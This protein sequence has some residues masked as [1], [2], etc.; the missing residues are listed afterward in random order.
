MATLLIDGKSYPVRDGQNLLQASLEL[1]L[2]LPYFCWHPALGSV[3]ACRQCAVKM[4]KDGQD[5]QGKLVMACMTPA[6]DGI[7]ISL[8]DPEARAFRASVI[9]WLMMSHPHDC[10]VCDEGGECHLQD[11]TVMTGHA[12]RRFRGRK[13]T[14]RN[15]DLGPFINHEMNRCIQCY[16]CVRFYRDYAGGRDFDAFAQRDHVYFGRHADGPLENEFSGNLVE[17]CPT[18]VFDD[19]TFKQHYTRKW[20]LQTA[21]SVCVHCGL[22]CNTIPGERYGMLRRIRNRYNGE[23]NGYFLCDRGRYGY[24]F[25][26][27]ERRPRQPVCRERADAGPDTLT[28][29]QAVSQVAAL[30]ADRRRVI[31]IGS[32]RASLEANFALRTLVGDE[33][34]YAGIPAPEQRVLAA[35]RQILLDGPAPT[36]SLRQVADADAVLVLG[37]D[38]TE[39]A[40]LLALA[41]RQSVRQQPME[42]ARRLHIPEWDDTAVRNALQ[43]RRGPVFLAA[44]GSTRLDDA[45]REAWHAAPADIARLGFVVAHAID[46]D[47][48]AV[49]DLSGATEEFA[50]RIAKALIAAERPVIVAG[51]GGGDEAAIHAAAN[52][53]WALCRSGRDARLCFTVPECNSLGLAFFGER[54]LDDAF[55]A[56]HDGQVDTLIVLEN[57]LY[58]R[59]TAAAMDGMLRSVKH[60]V[61]IDHSPSATTAAAEILLPAATFAESQGTLVNNEGRAQRF[62][63]IMPAAGDILTSWRWLR[64]ILLATGREPEWRDTDAVTAACAHA[65]PALARIT[66]AAPAADFRIVRQKIARQPERYSGRTSMHADVNVHEPKPPDDRDS[67]LAF[68]MEGHHGPVPAALIPRLWAP[69]WNSIQ[70]LNRFQEEIGGPLRD[71]DSG[72]RLIEPVA[73]ASAPYH[74]DVPPPFVCRQGEFL[75]LPA[76]QIFGSEELSLRAPAVAE[77]SPG[78]GV[79]LHPQDA[80]EIGLASGG[81]AHVA[82]AAASWRLPVRLDSALPRGIAMLAVGSPDVGTPPLPV[83]AHITAGATP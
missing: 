68:S 4:F 78:P 14:F 70:A 10:P 27:D 77:R 20:D 67:A 3:G 61:V 36:A 31:G 21:P 24:V 51:A 48:P 18:G 56:V 60:L 13:R 73:D 63:E 54:N 29:N 30:L 33:H 66:E 59:Y 72:V 82:L 6:T 74:D 62:F 1:G 37:E 50:A 45:V 12:Y 65:I 26:N 8:E 79:T 71:G 80:A 57:D 2:D 25:V 7:R 75:V 64:D 22:G 17:V 19:K 35:I 40:P 11:M 76:F 53:A 38:V 42:H 44:P 49:A 58:R 83:W 32:P 9:E 39:V 81:V 16:R 43:Q 52:V 23:V 69:G 15:Q 41:L 5:T 55:K 28:R 47:A 34:F 46:P